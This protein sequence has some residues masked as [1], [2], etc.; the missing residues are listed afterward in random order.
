[1]TLIQ[2]PLRN[3]LEENGLKDRIRYIVPVYGVPSHLNF[4]P[5]LLGYSVD[6]FIATTYSPYASSLWSPNP[7][8][9]SNQRF[10]QWTNPG[11]WPLYLV[12]RLD[13]PSAL[14]A[15]GLVDKAI[16]AE[17]NLKKSDGVAYF[18]IR[19]LQ[20]GDTYYPGDTW[21]QAAY[22]ES[23]AQ[24]YTSVLNHNH[25]S[26]DLMIHDA[27]NTL[28]AW[29]WY[30]FFAWDGYQFVN[31]A[32]GAMLTSYTANSIRYVSQGTWV[33]LWLQAG[34][35]ATWGATIEPTLYGYTRGDQVFTR[36]WS[37]FNFAESVYAATPALN[38]AMVFVGDPLY[39]PQPQ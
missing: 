36:L 30:T 38:W 25:N 10:A 23:V 37:G 17:A 13:G 6:S 14:I 20:P 26:S 8:L 18:D 16:S 29:G 35:T 4:S 11:G 7:Y 31:G 3:F 32:V 2:A 39:S 5:S 21:V 19:D 9:G 1:M 12:T 15:T 34:I 24:G 22:D 28:W 27:P 33:P